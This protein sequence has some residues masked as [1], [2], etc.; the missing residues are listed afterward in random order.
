[1]VNL[2]IPGLK[3]MDAESRAQSIQQ[4]IIAEVN[5]VAEQA[6]QLEVNLNKN[7]K[8]DS[9]LVKSV[10]D[11]AKALNAFNSVENEAKNLIPKGLVAN[12]LSNISK[13]WKR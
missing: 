10:S 2:N 12:L 3:E 5:R 6:N 11:L 13:L 7:A 4:A 1:M 8:S 9:D